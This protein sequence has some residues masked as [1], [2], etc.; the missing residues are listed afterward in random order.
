MGSKPAFHAK[1]A[2]PPLTGKPKPGEELPGPGAG[3]DLEPGE[4]V[5]WIYVWIFQN[6]P[7][8]AWAA[9]AYGEYPKE[10]HSESS[11]ERPDEVSEKSPPLEGTSWAIPTEMTDPSDPFKK[12]PALATA[13]SL[14]ERKDGSKDVYW[15]TVSVELE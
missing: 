7:K 13:M 3:G 14:I 6:G 1:L 10:E 2:L 12:G 11:E 5:H 8:D 9:A 4:K 15:W